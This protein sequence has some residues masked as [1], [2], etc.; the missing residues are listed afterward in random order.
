MVC[1][2]SLNATFRAL[3]PKT[4]KDDVVKF[5]WCIDGLHEECVASYTIKVD[6]MS[7]KKRGSKAETFEVSGKCPCEC[8]A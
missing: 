3:T 8:H 2:L 6:K 1:E 7:E 4:A 5:G